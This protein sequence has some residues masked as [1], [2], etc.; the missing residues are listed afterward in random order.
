MLVAVTVARR[1]L[2]VM[3]TVTAYG[4]RGPLWV[5]VWC[6]W[7]CKAC[8]MV[9]GVFFKCLVTALV[10]TIGDGEVLRFICY[11]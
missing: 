2:S 9:D 10:I 1:N 4:G 3:C 5:T 6:G 7:D 8:G 11:M